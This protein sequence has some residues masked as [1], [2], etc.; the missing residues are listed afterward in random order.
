MLMSHVP[1]E[2]VGRPDWE[3]WGM[4]KDKD[5]NREK[6]GTGWITHS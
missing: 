1:R 3:R 5:T 6:P 2:W 4:R